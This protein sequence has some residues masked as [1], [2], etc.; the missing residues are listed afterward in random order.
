MRALRQPALGLSASV[1]LLYSTM[2]IRL[3]RLYETGGYD[4]GIFGQYAKDFAHGRAPTSPFQ[5]KGASLSQTGP[6]LFGDHFSPILAVLGPVYRLWPHVE[7]L[8]AAQAALVAMSAFI[9]ARCSTRHLGTRRGMYISSAY[10]LSWG[11]QQL[12]GFDFHEVAFE[13]PL[14]SLA[15]AA[16]LDRR[17][18]TA[19]LWA[20]SLLLVKEDMGFTV[21]VFGLLLWRHDRRAARALCVLA[22]T[23]GAVILFV[24]M[25]HYTVTGSLGRVGDGA[26]AG[27]GLGMLLT[28]PWDLPAKLLWPPVKLLTV[29]MLLLPTAFLALRSPLILLAVP[30]LLWR[31]TA[32]TPNYW[33]LSWH[34]SAFLMPIAFLALA[35]ALT[36][37]PRPPG[38]ITSARRAPAA[39][40]TLA[41][42]LCA[43]FP[44]HRLAE[45]GFW[46][47]SAHVE[48]ENQAT[49]SI[50]PGV[51]VAAT[52]KIV[53]HLVDKATVYQLVDMDVIDGL[54]HRVDWIV[55][56]TT[57]PEL[58]GSAGLAL[59]AA[60]RRDGFEPT[61][62]RE[63]VIVLHR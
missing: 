63:G 27:G 12:V 16:Y 53:P 59:L 34:Y 47:T 41:V 37:L 14:I 23:A 48:A 56:D 24:V 20:A 60:L 35:D 26:D 11:V 9:V 39:V 43:V 42:A 13:L 17:W 4:L 52:D 3:H 49:D 33:G 40:F 29:L 31:F 38:I 45:P 10:A 55:A 58:R 28:H 46:G 8:L 32:N 54:P 2:A 5:A 7:T 57:T 6:N 25:P 19:A 44:L 30:T 22:L 62:D 61:F 18:R 1:F 36:R 50:P 15:I 51:L 21:L